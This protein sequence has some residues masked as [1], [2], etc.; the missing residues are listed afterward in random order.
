MAV[1]A[2]SSG[3]ANDNAIFSPSW[4]VEEL[5]KVPSKAFYQAAVD[6]L[7]K[8]DTPPASLNLMRTYAILSLVAIQYGDPRAMQGYLGKYHALVAMDGLHDE[9]NWPTGLGIIEIEERRRLV[10]G[11]QAMMLAP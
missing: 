6:A 11:S 5:S 8:T 10:G 9:Q 1:C 4:D 7:P 3:R 2:L